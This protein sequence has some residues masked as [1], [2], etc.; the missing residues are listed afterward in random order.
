MSYA[1]EELEVWRLAINRFPTEY[2]VTENTKQDKNIGNQV[3]VSLLKSTVNLI[4]ST[5]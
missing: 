5:K 1:C 4:K 3:K 2:F